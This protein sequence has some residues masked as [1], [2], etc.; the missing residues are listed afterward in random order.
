[1]LKE[2]Y[3]SN[4]LA[5]KI[6]DDVC[7]SRFG[8]DFQITPIVDASTAQDVQRT[9]QHLDNKAK[10]VPQDGYATVF[11]GLAFDENRVRT[12]AVVIYDGKVNRPVAVSTFVI[13]PRTWVQK[14]RY[15]EKVNDG[16]IIRDFTTISQNQSLPQF[17][18]FP[19]WT[20]VDL[21]YRLHFALSG[22][23]AIKRIMDTI[24]FYAPE[25]SWAEEIPRG[26]WPRKRESEVLALAAYPVGTYLSKNDLPFSLE[27]LSQNSLGS[28]SS[29]KIAKHLGLHRVNNISSVHTLGPVYVK[30]LG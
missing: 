30:Q 24:Q 4:S 23:R 17:L 22:F 15:F 7:S 28:S 18:F 9:I 5:Q 12:Q 29:V 25:R 16:I 26:R 27:A 6:C 2:W 13:A 8:N 20:Y 21:P 11:E 14:K 3:P 19:G 10:I 1:M